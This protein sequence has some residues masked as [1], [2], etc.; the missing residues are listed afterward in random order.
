MFW[1]VFAGAGWSASAGNITDIYFY[2]FFAGIGMTIIMLISSLNISPTQEE[3]QEKRTEQG[4]KGMAGM[5]ERLGW[6]KLRRK[7]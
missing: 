3:Q 6:R 4:A 7:N 5:R 2:L 1:M